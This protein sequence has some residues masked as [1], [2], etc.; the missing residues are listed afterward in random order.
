VHAHTAE[1][2]DFL[3]GRS[4]NFARKL[5]GIE[6]LLALRSEG[7]LPHNVSLNA[8]INTRNYRSMPEYAAFYLRMGINDVRFNMIR[9]DA[10]PDRGE[11]LTPRFKDLSPEITRAVAANESRLRMHM[12]F[13]DLPLCVYPWEILENPVLAARVVGEA[14]DLETWVSVFTA[15]KDLDT[16][17]DRFNWSAKKRSALKLQPEDPCSRCLR[18]DA[19]EGVWRSYH[20]LY[21]GSELGPLR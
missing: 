1:D 8:V 14:R 3:T 2:E 17:A 6:N 20:G 4:G 18:T 10:C 15:P 19:C 7:Y 11:E 12:S 13:G 5:E 9:T 16:E 21:G